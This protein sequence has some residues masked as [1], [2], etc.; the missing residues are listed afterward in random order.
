MV[1]VLGLTFL[2][3]NI[4][5]WYML[6]GTFYIL[7]IVPYAILKITAPIIVKATELHIN[8]GYSLS[9]FLSDIAG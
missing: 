6:K 9:D 8:K 4:A 5:I 2:S 3:V 7:S 1:R